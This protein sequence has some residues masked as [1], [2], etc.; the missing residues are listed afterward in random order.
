MNLVESYFYGANDTKIFYRRDIPSHAKAIVII[1]HGYMEHS[2]RYI[3]FAGELVSRNIGVCILDHR[4]NG[5]SEGDE[6]DIE[7][8][9]L[10]VRDIKYLVTAL[11]KYDKKIITFGHSMGGLIT[12]LYGLKYPQDLYAQV[13]ESPAL[14]VPLGCKYLPQSLYEHIGQLPGV[15]FYRIGQ[16]FSVRNKE[17]LKQFKADEMC[18]EFATARF[19]DQFLRIGMQYALEHAS[20]YSGKSL[21]LLGEKDHVIPIDRNQSILGRMTLANKQVIIYPKC[22]HDLL[23]ELD[24]ERSKITSD[25][26]NWLEDV[27]EKDNN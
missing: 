1:A 21:F 14:G 15:K 3:D 18:N 5:N 20:E 24:E 23:H 11:K 26:I 9:F 8:F 25:I 6:G 13:F 10:F 7:D 27:I 17:F 12:F 4:G 2:G 16:E 22:M 19:M